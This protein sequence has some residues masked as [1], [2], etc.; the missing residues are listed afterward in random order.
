MTELC[1]DLLTICE[2]AIEENDES[3]LEELESGYKE[4]E[5]GIAEQKLRTLLTGEYD[6]HNALVSFHAGAGGTEAQDWCAMLYRM[7]TRWAERHGF[8]YK[9]MDYQDG[10]TAGINPPIFSLRAKTPTASSRVK[11]AYTVWSVSLR[12][13]HPAAV[14]PRSRR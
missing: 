7:Y 8:T 4:L 2:M 1:D 10:D 9:I 5:D 6:S 13:M 3:M 12:L 14:R 11:T